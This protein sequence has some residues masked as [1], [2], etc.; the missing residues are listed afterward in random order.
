M[1]AMLNSQRLTICLIVA[2]ALAAAGCGG[3]TKTTTTIQKASPK[4]SIVQ[5]GPPQAVVQSTSSKAATHPKTARAPTVPAK[6]LYPTAL[7][8]RHSEKEKLKIQAKKTGVPVKRQYPLEAQHDFVAR[9]TAGGGSKSG[10][11]C[12]ITKLELSN[13]T[14]KEQTVAERKGQS[15]AELLAFDLAL[16]S[17]SLDGILRKHTIQIP[18]HAFV[19]AQQCTGI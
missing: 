3:G 11:E 7:S 17:T 10:C 19:Y 2:P 16:R 9:C 5:Q 12:I 6:P 18:H 13:V 1:L 4:A 15:L 8:E 14:E